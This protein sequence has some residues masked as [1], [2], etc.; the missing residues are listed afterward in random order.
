MMEN[1]LYNKVYQAVTAGFLALV[2]VGIWSFGIQEEQHILENSESRL[3]MQR[4]E[5]DRREL[6]SGLVNKQLERYRNNLSEMTRFRRD[7]LKQKDERVVAISDFLAGQAAEHGLALD[8]VRYKTRPLKE[9]QL[10]LYE[11]DLPLRGRYRDIRA[12]VEKVE[13]SDM[14]LIITRLAIQGE[15]ERAN[16][17]DVELSL[18]TYFEGG[19]P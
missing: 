15:S 5:L 19:A 1:F 8:Q 11:I 14:F 4:L 2:C 3:E 9:D 17:V 16:A 6:D 7:F 18:A 12:F 13:T 10:E